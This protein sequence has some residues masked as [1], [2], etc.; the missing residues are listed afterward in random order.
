[1]ELLTFS[2]E[3]VSRK[4]SGARFSTVIGT[5]GS[6]SDGNSCSVTFFGVSTDGV[7]GNRIAQFLM[8][9]S[10]IISFPS[11][12]LLIEEVSVILIRVITAVSVTEQ[13]DASVQ[14]SIHS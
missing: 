11:K 5:S 12:Q 2:R 8:Y 10:Q 4:L 7:A 9:G 13:H 14:I 1:M 3:Q 6:G